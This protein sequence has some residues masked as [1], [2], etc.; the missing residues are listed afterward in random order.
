MRLEYLLTILLIASFTLCSVLLSIDIRIHK[1]RSRLERSN[2]EMRDRATKRYNKDAIA[3]M[4][5][6]D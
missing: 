3:A 5:G 2:K 1:D 4:N 6:R